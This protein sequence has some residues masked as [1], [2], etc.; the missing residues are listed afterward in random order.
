MYAAETAGRIITAVEKLA[1]SPKLGRIV[2]EYQ[3]SSLR[4][5]IVGNYRV[6]YRLGAKHLGI[7][8]IVHGSRDLLRHLPAASW[9]LN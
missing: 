2:P 3:D 9:D 7:V 5:I 8:A 4:E 6:V 1:R